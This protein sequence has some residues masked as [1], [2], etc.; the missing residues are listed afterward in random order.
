MCQDLYVCIGIIELSRLFFVRFGFSSFLVAFSQTRTHC[1]Q[2]IFG[3][4]S[5][6]VVVWCFDTTTQKQRRTGGTHSH[7]NTHTRA[8]WLDRRHLCLGSVRATECKKKV[9]F[10]ACL[11][12]GQAGRVIGLCVC[13]I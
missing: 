10:G 1:E 13:V 3:P 4:S 7:T 12:L 2:K 8:H 9:I 6:S 5:L 11:P